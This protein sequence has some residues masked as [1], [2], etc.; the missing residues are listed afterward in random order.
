MHNVTNPTVLCLTGEDCSRWFKNQRSE[1]SRLKR[2]YYHMRSGQAPE[3]LNETKTWQWE[4]FMFMWDD[5]QTKNTG[6][7]TQVGICI[8]HTTAICSNSCI[9]VSYT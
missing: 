9:E 7:V 4:S 5:I 2:L 6:E 3:N 1:F 8:H